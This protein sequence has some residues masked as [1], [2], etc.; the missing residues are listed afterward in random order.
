[1]GKRG[2][3][4][5]AA[6]AAVAAVLAPASGAIAE[7]PAAR[8]L[9][10][11]VAAASRPRDRMAEYSVGSDY[12]GTLIRPDSLAQLKTVRDELGFRYIR[13]HDIFHDE[14][15]VYREVDGRPVYDW[16]RIDS[17]Y[18]QLLAMGIKPFIE[19]GFTPDAMKTSKSLTHNVCDCDR[20]VA[21]LRVMSWTEAMKSQA[22]E[23]SRVVSK[24]FARR[25]F[26]PSQAKVRSTTHRRGSSTKPLAVSD[27]LM[28]SMT[29]SPR[30]AR[31]CRSLSPA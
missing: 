22:V 14:M 13:F 19:L 30:P 21:S 2:L 3:T 4:L 12:P 9:V 8:T 23:L 27:R 24:S 17:L 29:Q 16:T 6:L 1:M 28:I 26:R 15:G 5:V 31:A 7:P 20:R 10:I 18:D 25:R 11:D